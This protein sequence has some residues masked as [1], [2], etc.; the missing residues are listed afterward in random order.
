M[1]QVPPRLKAADSAVGD[2]FQCCSS[3][4]T[5][6]DSGAAAQSALSHLLFQGTPASSH[7][8]RICP[9]LCL[10]DR[11]PVATTPNPWVF[12]KY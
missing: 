11:A 4:P 7:Q 12:C 6:A 8:R 5:A 10:D 2:F 3:K 9:F 1:I